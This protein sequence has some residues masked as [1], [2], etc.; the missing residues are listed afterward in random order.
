MGPG[1]V[2]CGRLVWTSG[3][4]EGRAE[5]RRLR[6]EGFFVIYRT[7][8]GVVVFGVVHEVIVKREAQIPVCEPNS[9]V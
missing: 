3:R 9:N 4:S 7:L 5:V 2:F 6:G 8:W 1:F